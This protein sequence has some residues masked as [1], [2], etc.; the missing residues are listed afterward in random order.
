MT[1]F[2][3][4]FLF[5]IC[6]FVQMCFINYIIKKDKYLNLCK[7]ILFIYFL[8]CIVIK[9]CSTV[10]VVQADIFGY[11]IIYFK[12]FSAL[13]EKCCFIGINYK[14]KIKDKLSF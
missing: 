14:R 5:F 12:N 3:V 2:N 6:I 9:L 1:F 10:M 11:I 7:S 13:F 8:I 4:F